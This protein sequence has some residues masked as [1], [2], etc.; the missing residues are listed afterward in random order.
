MNIPSVCFPSRLSHKWRFLFSN[1]FK[2][3]ATD[4]SSE[5]T[6]DFLLAAP[7]CPHW[8]TV[9]WE[10]GGLVDFSY[11]FV[12]LTNGSPIEWPAASCLGNL[13][14]YS[15]LAQS[16]RMRCLFVSSNYYICFLAHFRKINIWTSLLNFANVGE[17]C[18]SPHVLFCVCPFAGP[19]GGAARR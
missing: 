16:N 14:S 4:R 17:M 7:P 6:L 19:S 3:Q 1:V 9:S 2:L 5:S 8:P 10:L 12:N 18:S 13:S 15:R 11:M